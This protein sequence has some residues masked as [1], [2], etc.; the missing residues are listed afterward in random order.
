MCVSFFLS[1]LLLYDFIQV[2]YRINDRLFTQCIHHIQAVHVDCRITCIITLFFLKDK[3]T[4]CVVYNEL[5]LFRD[6][7]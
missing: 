7:I 4:L 1:D 2:I 6:N 3:K 5:I